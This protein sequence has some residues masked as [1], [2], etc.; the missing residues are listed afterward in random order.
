MLKDSLLNSFRNEVKQSN[1]DS[2]PGYVDSFAN[3]WDYEFGT[4]DNLPNDVEEIVAERAI[5]YGLMEY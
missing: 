3:L 4:L 1:A 5:E 2:F